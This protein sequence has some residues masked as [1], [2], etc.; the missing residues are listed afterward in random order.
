[1]INKGDINFKIAGFS[2]IKENKETVYGDMVVYWT[3]DKLKI[4]GETVFSV[5]DKEECSIHICLDGKEDMFSDEDK[6]MLKQEMLYFIKHTE[7][8]Y[9]EE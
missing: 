3:I 5:D 2:D 7:I 9:K 6:E 4:E 8:R 1:M